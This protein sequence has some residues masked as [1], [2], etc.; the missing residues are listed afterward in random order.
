MTDCFHRF[1]RQPDD[2]IQIGFDEFDDRLA[3][4]RRF[5]A[6]WYLATDSLGAPLVDR[7]P[8]HRGSSFLQQRPEDLV[9]SK[10]FR[11]IDVGG[12]PAKMSDVLIELP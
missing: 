8:H 6:L 7:Q 12:A 3:P 1:M 9:Q 5:M 2:H 11:S 10:I 4:T